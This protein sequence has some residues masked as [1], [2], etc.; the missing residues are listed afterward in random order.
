MCMDS[1]KELVEPIYGEPTSPDLLKKCLHGMTQNNNE[2]LTKL[3]W[4]RC[5]KETSVSRLAIEDATYSA[6]SYFSDGSA[7]IIRVFRE[8]KVVPGHY[9]TSGL[10]KG[11]N[12]RIYYARRKS[13]DRTK[14]R[15]KVLRAKRKNF[16]DNKENE[17][18]NVYEKG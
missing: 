15:R 1:Q 13:L 9:T 5:P 14:T 7:S 8:L 10:L 4:D 17:E 16:Q 18:G 3:I 12:T 11:D 2:S 6:V